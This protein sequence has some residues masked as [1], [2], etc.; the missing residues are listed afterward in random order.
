MKEI[1]HLYWPRIQRGECRSTMSSI[2]W[3][4]RST[5]D[6]SLKVCGI[7]LPA[8]TVL[9][10]NE[11]SIRTLNVVDL[12]SPASYRNKRTR[13]KAAVKSKRVDNWAD[14]T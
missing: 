7:K 12:P 6:K 11:K 10:L 9:N 1:F 13:F 5:A 2:A 4:S 3:R 8:L 14:C